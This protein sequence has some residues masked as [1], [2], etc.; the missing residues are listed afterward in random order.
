MESHLV[1]GHLHTVA[2]Q[3]LP[4]LVA[5]DHLLIDSRTQTDFAHFVF[6]PDR[7][8][9]LVAAVDRIQTALE[10]FVPVLDHSVQTFPVDHFVLEPN[11][12]VAGF[13]QTQKFLV[14]YSIH[15]DLAVADRFAQTQFAP[16]EVVLGLRMHQTG[17]PLDF[18]LHY[19]MV[20]H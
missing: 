20:L 18:S 13:V 19:P 3:I 5:A 12:A 7:Q 15:F 1:V 16:V 17:C 14:G 10:G 9:L 6:D 4:G 8:T 11:L 2:D